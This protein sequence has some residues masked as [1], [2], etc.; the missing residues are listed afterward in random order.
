MHYVQLHHSHNLVEERV[1][2][3][4]HEVDHIGG[5]E[6]AMVTRPV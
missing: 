4:D 1:E 2:V 3:T 5:M 6:P